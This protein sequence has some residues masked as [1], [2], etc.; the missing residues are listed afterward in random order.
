MSS[1]PKHAELSRFQIQT[2]LGAMEGLCSKSHL[3]LLAFCGE[4]KIAHNMTRFPS[5]QQHNN[6]I[7]ALV[8]EQLSAYF[9]KKTKCLEVPLHFEGTPFQKQIWTT[10]RT[11]PWGATVSY[12]ELA[13]QI[14][15][16]QATRAV[17]NA[18][19]ANPI[20]LFVPCHRVL[21]EKGKLCGYSGGIENKL[22]LLGWEEV[23]SKNALRTSTS[24]SRVSRLSYISP[25]ITPS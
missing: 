22:Q 9:D 18:V 4:G 10:L 16:P 17:A 15:R 3:H 7:A 6:P 12:S 2:P 25:K 19:A 11:L 8:K 24:T 14:G 21:G 5:Q 1:N 13:R 20:L 23:T